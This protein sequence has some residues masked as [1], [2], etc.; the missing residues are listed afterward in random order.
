MEKEKEIYTAYELEKEESPRKGI[1]PKPA[2]AGS[3]PKG[4][5]PEVADVADNPGSKEVSTPPQTD[6]PENPDTGEVP[7]STHNS[8]NKDSKEISPE[9]KEIDALI[10]E[11]GAEKVL[12]LIRGNRNAAIEQILKDLDDEE[13]PVL[14]SGLSAGSRPHSIFDLANLA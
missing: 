3:N 9:Q 12:Q 7:E 1:A 8:D 6:A 13:K 4:K 5:S 10:A 2:G 14:Q 11:I